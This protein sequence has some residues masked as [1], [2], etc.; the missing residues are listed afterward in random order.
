MLR[1]RPQNVKF[2]LSKAHENERQLKFYFVK[3]RKK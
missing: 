2:K 3:K 1:G